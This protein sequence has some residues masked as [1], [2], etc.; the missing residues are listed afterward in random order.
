MPRSDLTRGNAP[1]VIRGARFAWGERTF[2]MGI[3]NATP[4]SFSGDGVGGDAAAAAQRAKDFVAAGCHMI[5]IGGE[6]TRPGHSPVSEAD[7]SERVLPVIEAVRAAVDVPISIDT[8]KPAVAHAALAAGADMV[9]CVWGAP[10]DIA[11]VAARARAPLV[12]M[13]NQATPEYDGDVVSRVIESLERSVRDAENAGVPGERIIV[14]PGIGFGKTAEHNVEILARLREIAERL[15]FP[16]LVGTS[17][18]S[19]IGALTGQPVH[20]RAFG[21]AASV[22]LAIAGG[23]DIVRVH[24]VAEMMAA[25]AVADAIVR[26]S[27]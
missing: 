11:G 18:K 9:N 2:V 5:D 22:A 20:G 16:L 25:A 7:E 19:F 24:D 1:L 3:I 17:R 26:R 12:V 27:A 23:A 6:S 13:H 4:D 8:S 21:T 14:D 10:L 15:P